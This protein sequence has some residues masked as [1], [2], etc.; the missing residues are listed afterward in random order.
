MLCLPQDL[1]CELAQMR[2]ER[3]RLSQEVAALDTE[4]GWGGGG[5][6]WQVVHAS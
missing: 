5:G 1:E 6:M 4:V 2:A 3:L